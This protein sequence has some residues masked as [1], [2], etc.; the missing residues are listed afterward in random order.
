MHD[1]IAIS[2]SE[3]LKR[4]AHR[5]SL[6]ALRS[7]LSGEKRRSAAF[8]CVRLPYRHAQ[9]PPRSSTSASLAVSAGAVGSCAAR[10]Q[11]TR[12]RTPRWRMRPPRTTP[13]R[14]ARRRRRRRR[15]WKRRRRRR[16]DRRCSTCCAR[17]APRS[18]APSRR[19]T[20]R[21]SS[22]A[23]CARPPTCAANS[24]PPRSASSSRRRSR[25]SR[26]RAVSSSARSRRPATATARSSRRRVGPSLPPARTPLR[27]FSAEN[28]R[29]SPALAARR[30]GHLQ[31]QARARAA[32]LLARPARL[33]PLPPLVSRRGRD[34]GS[35]PARRAGDGHGRGRA[36]SGGD[37]RGTVKGN[38]AARGRAVLLPPRLPVARRRQAPRRG[39]ARSRFPSSS[40][41]CARSR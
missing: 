1:A 5:S 35:R 12:R 23:H 19:A 16:T 10:W 18:V 40:R 39:A 7:P 20:P 6:E 30:V 41:R 3:S 31:R 21:C 2:A 38:G 37:R 4:L 28:R 32:R 13:R 26:T 14:P 17:A 22:G 29:H 27:P 25:R 24:T 11:A 34:A 15:A 33:A 36:L 8:R 9:G